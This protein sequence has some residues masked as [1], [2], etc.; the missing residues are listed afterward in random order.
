MLSSLK[1]FFIGYGTAIDI[2]GISL[3]YH[4]CTSHA[5]ANKADTDALAKDWQAVGDSLREAMN[6]YER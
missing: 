6:M 4:I 5:E 2:G 1:T 3:D